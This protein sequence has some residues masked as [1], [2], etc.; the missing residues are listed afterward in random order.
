MWWGLLPTM[1]SRIDVNELRFC[2]RIHTVSATSDDLG[3]CYDRVVIRSR[4]RLKRELFDRSLRCVA[5][6]RA[7]WSGRVG[8]ARG[9]VVA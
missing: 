2:G 5:V 4:G 3:R 9:G 8:A 6:T 7:S 1:S